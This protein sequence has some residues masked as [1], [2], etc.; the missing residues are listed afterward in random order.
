M[1]TFRH[2]QSFIPWL[3]WFIH[4]S[5]AYQVWKKI[6]SLSYGK[7]FRHS[8]QS[9][10]H[11]QSIRWS[12]HDLSLEVMSVYAYFMIESK[13]TCN[14]SR[15]KKWKLRSQKLSRNPGK[16]SKLFL[17]K[18]VFWSRPVAFKTC[19][20]FIMRHVGCKP[21]ATALRVHTFKHLNMASLDIRLWH[22]HF[23][24]QV[25]SQLTTS[26][27]KAAKNERTHSRKKG[28]F[29]ICRRTLDFICKGLLNIFNR[30][31]RDKSLI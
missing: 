8:K 15:N 21:T 6:K 2:L 16:E 13:G 11:K 30:S 19:N 10:D 14:I 31:R 26:C 5:V 1:P 9:V 18:G 23:L 17:G 24:F 4:I 28:L 27:L 25:S 12:S 3:F 20:V 22:E 29:Q 7:R